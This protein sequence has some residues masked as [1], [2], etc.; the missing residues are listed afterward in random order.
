MS[1]LRFFAAG[2]CSAAFFITGANASIIES[3]TLPVGTTV[4]LSGLATNSPLDADVF[5]ADGISSITASGRPSG[6]SELY[7]AGGVFDAGR[8][9]F[10]VEN[11]GDVI[12]LDPG[13]RVD[14][15]SPIFTIQFTNAITA[16][17]LRFADTS[18]GFATPRLE[19]FNGGDS[20]GIVDID[21]PY[22][23]SNEFGFFRALGFTSVVVDVDT[24]PGFQDGV[25]ITAL[26][27][28]SATVVPIPGAGVL[29]AGALGGAAL[30]RRKA[31]KRA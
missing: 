19:F 20:V 16:F 9:L 23:A 12:A 13:A 1:A 30:M 18:N 14:F 17:G 2:V 10:V 3:N 25:G 5:A 31:N 7:D 6:N 26:T 29:M 11:T 27:L 4:D 15:G 24:Q 28:G 8:A 21:S 22:N